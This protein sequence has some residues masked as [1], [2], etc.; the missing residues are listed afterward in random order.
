[1]FPSSGRPCVFL[2]S[3][4]IWFPPYSFPRQ[5]AEKWRR[6]LECRPGSA[7]VVTKE[8]VLVASAAVWR[9]FAAHPTQMGGGLRSLHRQ[10]PQRS[11]E[12]TSELQ[13]LR[14]LVCR[15]LL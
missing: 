1:M 2:G 11:E 12:H 14:H 9:S 6:D 5:A 7:I 15:L 3:I 4:L 10:I 13:S 8:R